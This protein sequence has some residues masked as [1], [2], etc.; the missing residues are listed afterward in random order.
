MGMILHDRNL[1]NK[2]ML[3]SRAYR[4]LPAGGALIAIPDVPEASPSVC[5][6]T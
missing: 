3:I 6:Q 1:E 2:K 5:F 4:A